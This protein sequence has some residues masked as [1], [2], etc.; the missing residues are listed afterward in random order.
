MAE[1][2]KAVYE[3]GVFRPTSPVDLKEGAEVEI[4]PAKPIALPRPKRT[5]AEVRA[6]LK[7][8]ADLPPE[9]LDDDPH[10]GRDHDHYLYGAP[11]RQ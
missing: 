2:I 5:P 1:P 9:G 8:I 4:T 6:M 7:A 11:R 10:A 3:G